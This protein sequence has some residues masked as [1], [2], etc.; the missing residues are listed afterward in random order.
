MCC[1]LG[2]G[3]GSDAD[4]ILRSLG[5]VGAGLLF[6]VVCF[7]GDR[8]PSKADVV[9]DEVFVLFRSFL[10]LWLS[11]DSVDGLLLFLTGDITLP[12]VVASV[13]LFFDGGVL[14]LAENRSG[15]ASVPSSSSL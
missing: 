7:G 14:D 5:V 8:L 2:G 15:L 4:G 1:G 12:V 9:D 11:G 13:L 10:L 3:G 6:V